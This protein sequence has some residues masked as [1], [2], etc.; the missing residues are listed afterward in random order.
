MT[1]TVR[2]GAATAPAAGPRPGWQTDALCAQTDPDAFFPEVGGSPRAAV[3]TCATCPV[4]PDCLAY[5]LARPSLS[6][7]WGGLTTVQR[8]RLRLGRGA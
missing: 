3:R 1:T 8:D 7:I 5:A 6:G 4:R 2:A